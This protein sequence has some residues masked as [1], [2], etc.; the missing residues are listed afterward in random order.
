MQT[1][2]PRHILALVVSLIIL[3][4]VITGLILSGPPAQERAK[5]LDARRASDLRTMQNTIDVYWSRHKKLPSTF[6]E[7]QNFPTSS[8]EPLPPWTLDPIT[9]TPYEYRHVYVSTDSEP[10]IY[11]ELCAAFDTNNQEKMRTYPEKIYPGS[12]YPNFDL[13][14]AGRYCFLTSA[15]T[16]PVY[17]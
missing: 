13:H 4:S 6:I 2:T 11:Y 14:P 9:Q 3:V 15:N 17:P 5:R 1:F 10:Q 16:I 7:A 8:T 12:A